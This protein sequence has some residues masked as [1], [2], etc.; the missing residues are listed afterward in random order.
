MQ[1]S[2][3]DNIKGYIDGLLDNVSD[4]EL[5]GLAT[6]NGFPIAVKSRGPAAIDNRMLSAFIASII[7]DVSRSLKAANMS[8]DVEALT[9]ITSSSQILLRR[10]GDLIIVIKASPDADTNLL[11]YLINQDPF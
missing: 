5:V 6:A 1:N 4:I 2:F 8:A 11:L 10:K 3:S 9:I 7:N